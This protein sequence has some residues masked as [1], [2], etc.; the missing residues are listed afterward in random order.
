MYFNESNE[1]TNIDG[2]F[3]NKKKNDFWEN[4]RRSIIIG[5]IVLVFL[6]FIIGIII[7]FKN[8]TKY[9]LVLDGGN[10]I[11]I[12]QGAEYI[13][14]GYSAVDSKKN[15]LTS[16][17]VVNGTVDSKTIGTYTLT[18]QIKNI[19]K[20]RNINVVAQPSVRTII[21]LRGDK[22]MRIKVGQ[23]YIEPG[24]STVDTIDGDIT[25]KTNV[26]KSNLDTSKKGTYRI[27]YSVV[28]SDNITTSETRTIIV[29]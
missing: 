5:I 10:D 3:K 9:H 16:Q 15:N 14:P 8:R 11:T 19:T 20:T 24:F 2:E 23:K 17:V 13:D 6:I 22:T 4:N 25:S 29:E 1:D 26:N 12:Y 7:F 21:H 27:I 18:Y 28:N